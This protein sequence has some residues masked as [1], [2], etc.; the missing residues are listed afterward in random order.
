MKASF[1]VTDD[2]LKRI[3]PHMRF[4]FDDPQLDL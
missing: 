3:E 1:F 2:A 4:D